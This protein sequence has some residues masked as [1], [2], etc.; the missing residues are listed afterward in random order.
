MIAFLACC[1]DA[2]ELFRRQTAVL[3]RLVVRAR[4]ALF[5]TLGVLIDRRQRDKYYA[6]ANVGTDNR[7]GKGICYDPAIIKVVALL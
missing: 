7:R 5:D 6:T 1:A 3:D 4:L 2:V